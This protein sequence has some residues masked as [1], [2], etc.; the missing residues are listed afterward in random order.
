VQRGDSLYA[1]ARNHDV[2]V[3]ALRSA[4]AIDDP[5]KLR[6]GQTLRIP[7]AGS[8]ARNTQSRDDYDRVASAD[9]GTSAR[10]PRLAR[11]QSDEVTRQRP[12]P[13]QPAKRLTRERE[14]AALPDNDGSDT[15]AS[16]GASGSGKFGWPVRGR[17][18]SGFGRRAD[19]SHNDGID[20]AVPKGTSVRAVSDGVVA[21]A[22]SELKGYGNLVLIRHEDNWVSAYAHNSELLVSRGDKVRS[23]QVVAKAGRTGTVDQPQLHFELRQ[24]SKPVNPIEHLAGNL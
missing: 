24:G 11:R 4:N 15:F 20:I 8:A 19:G 12:Q 3:S 14:V 13:L 21:Y 10:T 1:I 16:G 2:T 18:I 9:P 23:G 6:V 17:I 22:G 5:T 7:G